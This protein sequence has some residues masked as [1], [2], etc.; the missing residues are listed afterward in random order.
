MNRRGPCPG[1][2]ASSLGLRQV[3][4]G[5]QDSWMGAAMISRIEDVEDTW[6]VELQREHLRGGQACLMNRTY[7]P[8]Y[9]KCAGRR[10]EISPETQ[11]GVSA[12]RICK[13]GVS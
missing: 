1:S 3:S 8:E 2:F 12:E 9:R 10:Q 4:A 11:T 5:S 13:Q 7:S 6:A